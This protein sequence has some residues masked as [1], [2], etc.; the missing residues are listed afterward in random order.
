MCREDVLSKKKERVF[1]EREMGVPEA[2]EGRRVKMIVGREFGSL[3]MKRSLVWYHVVELTPARALGS[4]TRNGLAPMH[5]QLRQEVH[6]HSYAC[7][8]E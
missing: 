2:S 7:R 6:V 1:S 5:E 8:A 3:L 4:R